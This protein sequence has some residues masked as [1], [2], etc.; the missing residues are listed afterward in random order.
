M[1]IIFLFMK[2]KNC[3]SCNI[4]K[5]LSEFNKR[6]SSSDGL[7]YRCRECEKL[8]KKKYREENPDKVRESKKRYREKNS[9]KIKEYRE[10]YRE[11]NLEK[12]K[13]YKKRYRE[14]NSEKIKEYRERYREKIKESKKRYQEK[15]K[16]SKKRYREKIKESKKRY[17]EKNH[18]QYMDKIIWEYSKVPFNYIDIVKIKENKRQ[19]T[20]TES[21]CLKC[22]VTK[23]IS[24]FYTS[25][26]SSCSECEKERQ[27]IYRLMN[28]EKRRETKRKHIKIKKHQDPFYRTMCS[29][30]NR[31]RKYLKQIGVKKDS[32][33]LKMIGCTPEE[34]RK[35]LEGRFLEGMCWDN[36]GID[37]WHIDHIVPISLAKTLDEVKTLCHYTNLRPMWAK[38][39]INKRDTITVEG[40]FKRLFP[41]NEITSNNEVNL[42]EIKINENEGFGFFWSD[43]NYYPI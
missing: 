22:G 26:L 41:Y 15:I 4:D 21:T 23:P 35:Y 28:P 9:E 12:I 10:R 18:I 16:E 43:N 42:I 13:E 7:N 5:E 40:Y 1:F 2:V 3:S 20:F 36:Y 11:E 6:R 30:R 17:Q 29:L 8:N 39:N 37:G 31:T 25:S 38:D 27:R 24:E 19:E 34:L 32:S 33:T 14:K